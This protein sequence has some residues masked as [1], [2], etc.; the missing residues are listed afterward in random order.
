MK[1]AIP[2]VLILISLA[3]AAVMTAADD[4]PEQNEYVG[5]S[6]KQCALCHQQQVEAWQQWP[7]ATTW[8]RLSEKE[9]ADSE[10]IACHSTGFGDSGGF[11]SLKE[12]P[13]L[14]G[15]HC[16]ACHGPA[17]HHLAAP[18]MDREQRRSTILNPDRDCC[19]SCHNDNSPTF[20]GFDYEKA[21]AALHDHLAPADSSE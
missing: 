2:V 20:N 10:C 3:A 7:M 9:Q 8:E 17:K 12:T 4:Q 21:L 13:N 18:M 19:E 6:A 15:V 1:R 16:E 5:N 14:A 11:A